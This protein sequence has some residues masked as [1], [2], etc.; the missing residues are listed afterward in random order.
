MHKDDTPAD[1]YAS[2]GVPGGAAREQGSLTYLILI[3]F[4]AT[5][6]GLLFGYDTAVI[7]GAIGFLKQY[8]GLS[9]TQVGWTAASALAGCVVGAA[10]AGISNDYLGRKKVLILCAVL[11]IISA[12]G[13]ALPQSQFMFVIF[14]AVGGVGVGAAAMTSPMYIAEV[15]PARIRGR[16]VSLNQL[17]IVFGML[18]VY[19][20]NYFIASSGDESWNVQYGWRWMFGSETL[21]AFGLLSLLFFVPESPRWLVKQARA[22]EALDVLGR[23]NGAEQARLEVS[24]IKEAIRLES[25]SLLQLL[26]PGRKQRK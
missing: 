8:F 10:L 2:P 3:C 12:I 23:V 13:T 20:V 11:F 26:S 14:R 18:A 7:A 19:F 6:G 25:E 21:P 4:V 15:S 5:L 9:D 1:A 24:S 22:D 17:A 16:M